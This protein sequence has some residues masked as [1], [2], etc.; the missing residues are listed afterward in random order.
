MTTQTAEQINEATDASI[1]ARTDQIVADAKTEA[2]PKATPRKAAP[3]AT[4]KAA[5]AKA[6]P[7]A[8]KAEPKAAPAEPKVDQR[9]AKQELVRIALQAMADAV[10]RANGL[11]KTAYLAA[12]DGDEALQ[13][14]SQMTHHFPTGRNDDGNRWWPANLPKPDRSDWR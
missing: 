14:V 12:F 11:K 5:P 4:A 6:A 13:I 9:A 8:P 10:G 2:K 1:A 7:K 3:K